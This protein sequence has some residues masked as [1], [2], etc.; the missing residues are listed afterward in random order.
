MVRFSLCGIPSLLAFESVIR[1]MRMSPINKAGT[2]PA[3]FL[4]RQR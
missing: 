4:F 3:C 1:L 2:W